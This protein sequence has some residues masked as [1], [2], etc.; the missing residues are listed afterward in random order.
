[1]ENHIKLSGEIIFNKIMINI[2][3]NFVFSEMLINFNQLNYY[4]FIC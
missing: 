2:Y 1:M 4:Y 3:T